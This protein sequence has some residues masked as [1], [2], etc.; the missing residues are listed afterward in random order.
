MLKL[1]RW[2]RFFPYWGSGDIHRLVLL[3]SLTKLQT[4]TPMILQASRP[5]FS[6]LAKLKMKIRKWSYF[7]RNFWGQVLK[8]WKIGQLLYFLPISCQKYVT[9][10][11]IIFC[12]I[13]GLYL[14]YL[15]KSSCGWLSLFLHLLWT[16]A[17][18]AAKL[19]SKKSTAPGLHP[20]HTL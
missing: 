14:N 17:T 12:F 20:I 16:I 1:Q 10:M 8:K 2:R 4:S 9:R 5:A 6:L 11:I 3:F 13:S 15:A 19:F 18:Q 7:C